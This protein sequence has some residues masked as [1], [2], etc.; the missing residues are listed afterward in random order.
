MTLWPLIAISPTVSGE[1]LSSA[2]PIGSMSFISTPGI[3]SPM[4]PTRAGSPY[5]LKLATGEVSDSPYPSR[6]VTPNLVSTFL[7]TSTGSAAPPET[8]TRRFFAIEEMSTPCSSAPSRAQYIVGTPAKN[9]TPAFS[10]RSS[11]VRASKRG[12]MTTVPPKAQAVFWITVCPKEW[13]SGST[14]R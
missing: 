12:S 7:W 5:T 9:V 11:A 10:I 14:H 1:S 13:K 2:Q 6:I 4:D 3:G 8:A